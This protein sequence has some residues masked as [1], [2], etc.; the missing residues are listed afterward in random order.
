M[1]WTICSCGIFLPTAHAVAAPTRTAPTDTVSSVYGLFEND[2]DN[3]GEKTSLCRR[4]FLQ[5]LLCVLVADVSA[6]EENLCNRFEENDRF[7][8][9]NSLVCLYILS[10]YYLSA[11]I[12]KL[13]VVSP[14]PFLSAATPRSDSQR[15]EMQGQT[16]S[17][18]GGRD[19]KKQNAGVIWMIHPLAANAALEE[20]EE[21]E[22]HRCRFC[23]WCR[24]T[25]PP[26]LPLCFWLTDLS[27]L[28]FLPHHFPA[29]L[30]RSNLLWLSAFGF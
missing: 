14:L 1:R 5:F 4:K 6:V 27:T 25:Y 15:Q 30:A 8:L 26:L 13:H 18:D 28:P 23:F 17:P 24:R 21:G 9:V 29:A 12:K 20:S 16:W 7:I 10:I 11:N 22:S 19:A 3:D 2:C